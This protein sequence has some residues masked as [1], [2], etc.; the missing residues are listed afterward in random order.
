MEIGEEF[1]LD[2]DREELFGFQAS[3][4]CETIASIIERINDGSDIFPVQVKKVRDGY[5]LCDSF[6]GGHHRAVAHYIEGRPLRCVLREDRFS[7]LDRIFNL[8][9]PIANTLILDSQRDFNS[10]LQ[11]SSSYRGM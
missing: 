10:S 1:D 11:D 2:F 9:I 8:K 6:D 4:Y 3:V 7:F 5:A